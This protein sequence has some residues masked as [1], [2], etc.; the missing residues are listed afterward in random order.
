VSKAPSAI[1]FAIADPTMSVSATHLLVGPE[2]GGVWVEDLGSTNG[3][4]IVDTSREVRPLIARVRAS[5]PFGSQIRF[6]ECW[7]HV[8][9]AGEE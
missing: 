2:E 3:T 1:A 7:L 5:A 9:R 8:V 4:E 6:G